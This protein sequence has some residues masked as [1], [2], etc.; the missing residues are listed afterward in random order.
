MA[1]RKGELLPPETDAA[2]EIVPYLKAIMMAQALILEKLEYTLPEETE[3]AMKD[4]ILDQ[5]LGWVGL[6]RQK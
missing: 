2:R 3:P 5:I 4:E 1:T 6:P